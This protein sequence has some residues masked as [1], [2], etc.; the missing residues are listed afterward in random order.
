MHRTDTDDA[1][2]RMKLRRIDTL[3]AGRRR[4]QRLGF[5]KSQIVR[6][7]SPG[8]R[9]RQHDDQRLPASC[10]TPSGAD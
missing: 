9:D 4:F 1:S 10:R 5:L 6:A 8:E 3:F 2:G 7:P